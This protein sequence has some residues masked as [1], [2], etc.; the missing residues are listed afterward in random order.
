[1]G[2]IGK[3]SRNLERHGGSQK[4]RAPRFVIAERSVRER[5]ELAVLRIGF[6]LGIPSLCIKARKPI[7]KRFQLFQ[8][9]ALYLAFDALDPIHTEIHVSI[10]PGG[11]HCD[12]DRPRSTTACP[13]LPLARM[14]L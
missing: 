4:R 1:M 10:I 14:P 7:P 8:A 13:S 6:D 9:Q 5:P 12:Q 11:T 2:A 3:N